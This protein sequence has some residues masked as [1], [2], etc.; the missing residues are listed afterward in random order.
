MSFTSPPN[1]TLPDTSADIIRPRKLGTVNCIN[2]ARLG[3]PIT[4]RYFGASALCNATGQAHP[5]QAQAEADVLAWAD[6]KH[7]A[8]EQQAVVQLASLATCATQPAPLAD[9]AL[10]EFTRLLL[11]TPITYV[12]SPDGEFAAPMVAGRSLLALLNGEPVIRIADAE[13]LVQ[14]NALP[15]LLAQLIPGSS[16]ERA[17][18]TWAYGQA[19]AA[20]EKH[21]QRA[22]AAATEYL[23]PGDEVDEEMVNHFGGVVSPQYCTHH[24]TQ[25]G[26]PQYE[27][28]GRFHYMTFGLFGERYLYLGILPP[29]K[30]PKY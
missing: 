6:G 15:S 1:L 25:V 21:R 18:T 17:P 24:F 13:R 7:V 26:E 14:V 9:A 16:T 30:Q 29:F 19:C 23:Q 10:A 5:T 11:L 2:T 3:E 8:Y 12:T 4:L 27:R 20:L 28:D 22:D